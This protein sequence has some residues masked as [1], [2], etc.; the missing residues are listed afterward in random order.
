MSKILKFLA[1]ILAFVLALA[2]IGFISEHLGGYIAAGWDII[3]PF[4]IAALVIFVVLLVIGVVVALANGV[5]TETGEISTPIQP[6]ANKPT[7]TSNLVFINVDNY[8][9]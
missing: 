4:L 6:A 9:E 2:F 7:P 3:S 5:D 8:E 1:L